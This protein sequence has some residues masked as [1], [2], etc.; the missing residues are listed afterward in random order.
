MLGSSPSMTKKVN[1]LYFLN[2][3][4][5]GQHGIANIMDDAWFLDTPN[6]GL[7]MDEEIASQNISNLVSIEN[8]IGEMDRIIFSMPDCD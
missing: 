7:V 1:S 3:T 6:T 5:F 8:H 4:S 2:A